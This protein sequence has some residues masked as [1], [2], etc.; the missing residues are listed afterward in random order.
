MS[1]AKSVFNVGDAFSTEGLVV[2]ANYVDGTSAVITGYSVDNAYNM[3]AAGTYT[4]TVSFGGK[5]ASYIIKVKNSFDNYIYT[6]TDT[7]SDCG[8]Y[9][10][11]NVN[12][13][14]S[15][16]ALAYDASGTNNV[17]QVPVTVVADGDSVYI[18]PDSSLDNSIVLA[19]AKH[20]DVNGYDLT[21]DANGSTYFLEAYSSSNRVY[22]NAA[23]QYP[24]RS[25]FYNSNHNLYENSTASSTTSTGTLYNHFVR[26]S[27]GFIAASD[28]NST[29][30]YYIYIFEKTESTEKVLDSISVSGAKDSFI[31]GG[32]FSTE[33]LV[34]TAHFTDGST[35]T[36]I[37]YTVDSSAVDFSAAGTYT[38]TVSYEGKTATYTVS[39]INYTEPEGYK[40]VDTL[41]EGEYLI[42][43][44]NSA[45]QA[46]AL[47]YNSADSNGIG[48]V[49][50]QITET[51]SGDKIILKD[52]IDSNSVFVSEAHSSGYDMYVDVDGVNYYLEIFG[53]SSSHVVHI[54]NPQSYSDRYMVY[55]SGK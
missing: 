38:V 6:L 21:L 48:A 20:N 40:L 53:Q 43:S 35:R 23:Q 22:L 18:E 41:G 4:V 11:V 37:N 39:V 7:L 19:S 26:Y 2:T 16:Y 17:G 32:E 30:S 15:G 34:V 50:C 49:S 12:S 29:S 8:E 52:S 36:V 51:A 28:S 45:G 55:T 33:G 3:A 9:L 47:T 46:Y 31:T 24:D 44:T 10:I 5:T 13:E 25:W 1:G 42:V 54:A 27:N 14:G